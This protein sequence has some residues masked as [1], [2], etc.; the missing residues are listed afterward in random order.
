MCFRLEDATLNVVQISMQQYPD[1]LEGGRAEDVWVHLAR[2]VRYRI[3][4]VM[5]DL[6][7]VISIY[8]RRKRGAARAA[9][10]PPA[11]PASDID[12]IEF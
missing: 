8:E 1:V 10:Q 4:A 9:P 5:V 3:R 11:T 6:D 7:D 12:E 2:N